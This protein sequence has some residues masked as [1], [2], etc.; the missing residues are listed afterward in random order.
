MAAEGTDKFV[1]VTELA[2]QEISVEQLDRL[3]HRYHWAASY[4]DGKDVV[5][6]ACGGGQGLGL[7][8]TH[9]RSL[10]GTDIAPEVL[11]RARKTY[12]DEIRLA[13][14]AADRIDV[15]SATLDVILLFEA[16]YYLPDPDGFFAEASRVLR[17]GGVLLITTANKDLFDFTRSPHS[18][19]Y[20]GVDELGR[21]LQAH[22]FA[23]RMYGY[24]D[25]ALLSFRQR[26][27]RPVKFAA[28]RL[29]LMPKTM[30]G[31]SILKRVVFG[32][33]T[34]M[35]NRIDG[36]EYHFQPPTLLVEDK[37]NTNF[38]VIYCAAVKE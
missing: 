18:T 7:L 23:S 36:I 3:C 24:V 22:G 33:M 2:G 10:L 21:M 20:F 11:D 34:S 25:T 35:P 13:V 26:M 29:R 4:C 30:A 9:A 32:K 27:F 37:P 6:V 1:E 28:N 14:G 12:D 16:L 15:P 5:E 31:K 8:A 19:R 17:P 38:K